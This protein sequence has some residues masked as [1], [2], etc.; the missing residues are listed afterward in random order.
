MHAK[1]NRVRAGTNPFIDPE[2]YRA[3][4]EEHEQAFKEKLA[5]QQRG[6]RP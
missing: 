5:A 2:G 1:L 3:F 6:G 4:V